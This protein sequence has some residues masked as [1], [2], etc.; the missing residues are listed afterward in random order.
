MQFLRSS[1]HKYGPP[2]QRAV[3]LR[4]DNSIYGQTYFQVTYFRQ[5]RQSLEFAK[6]RAW[7][8]DL[9]RQTRGSRTGARM[10]QDLTNKKKGNSYM[11]IWIFFFFFFFFFFFLESC[12]VWKPSWSSDSLSLRRSRKGMPQA[13]KSISLEV[14]AQGKSY[15]SGM[16]RLD[17]F[18]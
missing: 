12:F 16:E 2:K 11:C 10:V 6:W 7:R 3:S 18:H 1:L 9:Y 8:S 13:V 14:H 5:N 15:C 17:H 4:K